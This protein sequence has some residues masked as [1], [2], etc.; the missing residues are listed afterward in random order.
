MDGPYARFQTATK[1]T[2]KATR[3][4]RLAFT[5]DRARL[6]V[7]GVHDHVEVRTY[8]TNENPAGHIKNKSPRR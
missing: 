1:R 7:D 6:V 5:V 3:A 2:M 8:E 4:L